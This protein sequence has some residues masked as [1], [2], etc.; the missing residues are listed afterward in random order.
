MLRLRLSVESER[1]AGLASALGGTH[2]VRRVA[3][4]AGAGSGATVLSA[5]VAPS[6]AD[7]VMS[8]LRDFGVGSDDYVLSRLEVVAPSPLSGHGPAGV[9]HFTWVEVLGEARANS[10]PLARY[11]T[12]MAVAAMIA[13]L[14]VLN[15]NAILIVGAMAV[16]PD[17]L[18][19]C[20]TCVGIVG[21]RRRLAAQ[22]FATLCLGLALVVG[23]SAFLAQALETV[24]I[25]DSSFR[26]GGG[27]VAE[28]VQF[29]YG[30]VL[31]AL[32][33]G[34]AAILAFETRASAAVGV[35]ISVATI[36]AS[37]FIGVAAATDA[38]AGESLA[39]LAANVSMLIVS[40]TMTLA[41]QRRIAR[42]G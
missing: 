37:A 29:D 3:S 24:G 12:L 2:G 32:A 36:P 41:I 11:V 16:S 23:F 18:P 5:D 19:V 38:S 28:L 35:A 6:G 4:E 40:G 7:H 9:D 8:A 13:A 22:A 39:V 27:G 25:V 33:A 10:R 15:G 21:G 20:A 17:L 42:T 31:V 1:A 34:V 14:G 30:T 26:V